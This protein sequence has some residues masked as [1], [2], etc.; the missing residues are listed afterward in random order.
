[1]PAGQNQLWV[2]SWL[3]SGLYGYDL[4]H[5]RLGALSCLATICQRRSSHCFCFSESLQGYFG[6]DCR[7]WCGSNTAYDSCHNCSWQLFASCAWRDA[8]AAAHTALDAVRASQNFWGHWHPC[9]MSL[10]VGIVFQCVLGATAAAR[11]GFVS[12]TN[13]KLWGD[14]DP[15]GLSLL[16]GI[17]FK[18][19]GM[20]RGAWVIPRECLQVKH[21]NGMRS[22]DVGYWVFCV[23]KT[24]ATKG[25]SLPHRQWLYLSP[26]SNLDE[27]SAFL[28]PWAISVSTFLNLV[29]FKE[30]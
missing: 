1:M 12:R 9:G 6:H 17:V 25:H 20:L 16:V 8:T 24:D 5:S 13:R 23:T 28:L 15:C 30:A 7:P 29:V 2:V 4:L 21:A 27:F 3:L 22:V 14:W 26:Q 11:M 19:Q 18:W 10:L